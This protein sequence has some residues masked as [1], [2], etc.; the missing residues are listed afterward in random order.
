MTRT[1][2]V[3]GSASGIGAATADLLRD[4]GFRVIGVDLR[5]ADV[6]ADLSTPTAAKAPSRR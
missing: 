2:V 3:T 4:R 5:D 1:F 6:M